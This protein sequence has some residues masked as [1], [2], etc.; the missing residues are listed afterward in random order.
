MISAS[1]FLAWT[2]NS[3]WTIGLFHAMAVLL[4]ACPCALGL[5]T[6][7]ALWAALGCLASRGFVARGADSIER[8]A[9]VDTAVFD[10][11]GTLTHSEASLVEVVVDPTTEHDEKAIRSLVRQVER[12]ANHP[13][14]AA[15]LELQDGQPGR[16]SIRSTSLIPAVGVTA[17]VVDRELQ[18]PLQIQIGT[19]DGLASPGDPGVVELKKKL[20]TETE[21]REILAVVDGTPV[22]LAR[23]SE[24]FRQSWQVAHEKLH[25]QGIRTV[26][27][28]GDVEE[29]A[30]S[31][32]AD[33]LLAELLP[34]EKLDHVRR[35]QRE[36]HRL[37]FVGDGV[38][39]AAALAASDVGIGL[40]SGTDLAFEVADLAWFGTDLNAIPRAIDA[41]RET[42]ATIRGNLVFAL[43]YNVVGVVVAAAGWLHPV[44]AT[45]LMTCSSLVVTW[46]SLT[47]LGDI[48]EERLAATGALDAKDVEV[49]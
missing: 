41:A 5:A 45:L 1:T 49:H 14:A 20:V 37:V 23:V 31:S 6:P 16:F 40:Q 7:L 17:E 27:M 21:A 2:L 34:E 22:L 4:I 24:R 47:V 8:L 10:K 30:R 26:V 46:R 28:T 12:V 39:D 13:I 42:L 18:K 19:A 25:E 48:Q 43:A 11:T 33:V 3:G 36:G 15:F 44:A 32:G 35:L 29:R 38:N 9:S